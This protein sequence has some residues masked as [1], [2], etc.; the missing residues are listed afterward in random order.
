MKVGVCTL[1]EHARRSF[2]RMVRLLESDGH[3]KLASGRR[4]IGAELR[5][6]GRRKLSPL[7]AVGA[8]C[9]M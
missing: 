1:N 6:R 7:K 4:R 8:L 3:T 2:G 5:T 9:E